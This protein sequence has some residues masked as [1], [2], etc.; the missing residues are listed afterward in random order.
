MFM[1]E[2]VN[3]FAGAVTI[4]PFLH[5]WSLAVEEQFYL[6]WP[7]LIVLASG[8]SL[9]R[10]RLAGWLL[11][12]TV[13]SLAASIWVTHV[14]Q[15]S[16]FF[17]LP[18]RAWEFGAGGLACLLRRDDL[19]QKQ[20]WLKLLSWAGFAA[21]LAA[22]HYFYSVMLVFPG[23]VALVP[24]AGTLAMLLEGATGTPSILQNMLGLP[25]M[26]WLGR[27]SYSWYLWHWPFLIYAKACLPGLSWR[28]RLL[29]AF[30]AL[31]M[32]QLTYW[33]LENPVRFNPF[34][35][36]R[37]ALSIGLA[38]LV[39]AVGVSV[40][41][42]A[43]HAAS[44]TLST[45]QQQQIGAASA[46]GTWHDCL[47]PVGVF[48]VKECIFGDRGS[49]TKIVLFGDSH[50]GQW[51]PAAN[52]MA[53]ERHWQLVTLL[54]ANCQVAAREV[55]SEGHAR[56][57][58]C[59]AWQ[60][61][62]IERIAVLRPSLVMLG[63]SA[64]G[65]GNP[66]LNERPVTPREWQVGLRTV[67]NKLDAIGTKTLV[68]ADIPYSSFDVPVCLSR[69]ASAKW[70]S[71]SCVIT[72]EAGLNQQVRDLERA[73]V[74]GDSSVR[75]VDFSGLFCPGSS[76]QTIIDH[77]VAYRDDSHIS[78]ILALHLAPQLLHEVDL[79]MIPP[80]S[81]TSGPRPRSL[82]DRSL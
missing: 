38:V 41:L 25:V 62:A 45:G 57:A 33:L 52:S 34:L 63:E 71:K 49:R 64:A 40:A 46:V 53:E 28:G 60:G 21:L 79:L 24:V 12:V 68:M 23:Y 72:R 36:A 35:M 8:R 22:G 81:Q 70:G 66:R 76:C 59:E 32:A 2:A 11:A 74:S 50:A 19:L 9:S 10:G 42:G 26:Q 4:N 16:A 61:K 37:P 44:V 56:D 18:T 20:K 14:S 15:P 69:A 80:G 31:L 67:L 65:V 77:L 30:G 48:D 6:L 13:M 27:L 7:A 1:R 5:T 17:S 75:W 78:E 29:V 51:F 43:N 55:N 82:S 58:S 47:V 73:A 3:Y 54:K 39:P